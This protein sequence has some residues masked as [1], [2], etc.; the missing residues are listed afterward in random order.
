[1]N[2]RCFAHSNDQWVRI[3]VADGPFHRQ[4]RHQQNLHR[5]LRD[6]DVVSD[7]GIKPTTSQVDAVRPQNQ[8]AQ[9]SSSRL[10]HQ[11]ERSHRHRKS[12]SANDPQGTNDNDPKWQSTSPSNFSALHSSINSVHQNSNVTTKQILWLRTNTDQRPKVITLLDRFDNAGMAVHVCQ[13]MEEFV[14]PAEVLRDTLIMVECVDTIEQ[15]MLLRLGSVRS[16]SK[17]PLIVLT[18]NTTLDWSLL[19]LREGADAIFTLNT[20]D[21]IILARSNALLRR[22]STE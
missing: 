15:E 13:D 6:R 7:S 4:Y 5:N 21:D 17:A 19:A 3:I 20:P 12:Q 1:M 8:R 9:Y 10:P 2:R 16:Q 11:T 22:W 14:I 18:D